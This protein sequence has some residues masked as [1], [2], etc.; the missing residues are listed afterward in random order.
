MGKHLTRSFLVFWVASLLLSCGGGGENSL[1]G[2]NPTV[3]AQAPTMSAMS[4]FLSPSQASQ[5][6]DV[7]TIAA[8]AYHTLGLKGDGTVAAAGYNG[9]GQLNVSSWTNIKAIA[10]GAHHTVGL[11]EDGT[12]VAAGYNGSGELN[13]SSWTNIKAIAAGTYHTV[14]LKED[15]T[16][17]AA[18]YNGYGQLNVSSWTNIKAIAAGA[19]H[20]VG[21]KEDGTVVAAGYNGYGQ[22]NVSSWTNIKAI[23]AGTYH[24]VGLKEDGTVVTVGYN[25]YGQLNVSSWTNIK[26][27]ATGEHHTVGL[28]EDG[29]VVA[30]GY[31]GYDMLNVSAWTNIKAIAAGS[32]HTVG[33]KEDGTAA[34]VGDN[35]YGQ[36]NVSMWTNIMPLCDVDCADIT[37]PITTAMT[38]GALGD[39]GWYVSDV[40]LA[41]TA[42]D[43]DGG[44]GVKEIHYTVDGIETV[45]QGSIASQVITGDG[46]HTVT[47]YAV[48]NAGNAET[49]SPE[50]D[51]NIDTTAPAIPSFGTDA[52]ILWPPNHKMVNVVIGGSVAESGSGIASAIITV[53][54]EYG[55]CD[56]SVQGFGSVIPLEA[57]REGSDMDGRLYTITAVVTDNAGNRST[58]TTMVLVPHN[59]S[60]K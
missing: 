3:A 45:V 17:V 35:R 24:T 58:G 59:M 21:L 26:A 25:G 16:V 47:F 42:T 9:Y 30:V 57:W 32:Y 50:M 4:L 38:T 11:K 13:V 19:Y 18:G 7:A 27:I 12:V 8:N 10:A 48:D 6:S 34:A 31:N 39:N 14:G 60:K 22:L 46:T 49:P 37:P 15:G 5:C 40:Q 54:D 28:K 2:Q 44:S 43:N 41:L 36:L 56:R 20:T 53:A 1:V 55:I 33:L 23:A 29:T 52:A 51:V